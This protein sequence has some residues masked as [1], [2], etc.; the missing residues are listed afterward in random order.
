MLHPIG[1][2]MNQSFSI[3]TVFSGF[4]FKRFRSFCSD[5]I[6]FFV[7]SLSLSTQVLKDVHD[8]AKDNI[9]CNVFNSR[10]VLP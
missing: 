2:D 6:N 9:L 8:I 4:R 10:R 3:N 7:N 5:K 1:F